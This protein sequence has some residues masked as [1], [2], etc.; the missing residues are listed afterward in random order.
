MK[1]R[2]KGGNPQHLPKVGTHTQAAAAA[3]QHREREAVLDV[4]GVHHD[5]GTTHWFTWVAIVL[6]V[7]VAVL[8]AMSLAFID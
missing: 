1:R 7:V 5:A 4:M 3:E 8:G 2:R 6:I